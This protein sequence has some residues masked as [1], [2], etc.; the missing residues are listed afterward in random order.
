MLD[1][2]HSKNQN[3]LKSEPC[4]ANTRPDRVALDIP[5]C[6]LSYRTQS[7][8]TSQVFDCPSLCLMEFPLNIPTDK[9]I[10]AIPLAYS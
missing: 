9:I 8:I 5:L 1:F 10:T 2:W 6:F 4:A 7:G 3:F